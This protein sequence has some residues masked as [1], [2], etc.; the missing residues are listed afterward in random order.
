M[1]AEMHATQRLAKCYSIVQPVFLNT[2]FINCHPAMS[3]LLCLLISMFT[4]VITY[5]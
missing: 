1:A 3:A 4:V 2:K 5:A